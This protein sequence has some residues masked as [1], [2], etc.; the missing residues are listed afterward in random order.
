MEIVRI[1]LGIALIAGG[2]VAD[3]PVFIFFGA[4]FLFGGIWL[5]VKGHR[6]ARNLRETIAR[7]RMNRIE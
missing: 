2:L 4:L 5:L 6:T 7:D 3:A 1:P